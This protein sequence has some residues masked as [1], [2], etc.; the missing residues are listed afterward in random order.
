MEDFSSDIYKTI[1]KQ[2]ERQEKKKEKNSPS[3]WHENQKA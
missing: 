1:A 3:V 2:G